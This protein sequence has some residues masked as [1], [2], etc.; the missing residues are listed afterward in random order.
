MLFEQLFIVFFHISV[1]AEFYILP[2]GSNPLRNWH[3]PGHSSKPQNC[4]ILLLVMLCQHLYLVQQLNNRLP[5]LLRDQPNRADQ[6]PGGNQHLV[7]FQ[8]IT[9]SH[10]ANGNPGHLAGRDGRRADGGDIDREFCRCNRIVEDGTNYAVERLPDNHNRLGGEGRP[11]ID[12]CIRLARAFEA[13]GG[14]A[15]DDFLAA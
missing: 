9:P 10:A 4:Q 5:H 14:P 13:D 3:I 11:K 1:A 7:P 2:S 15:A 12:G 8:T 6:R